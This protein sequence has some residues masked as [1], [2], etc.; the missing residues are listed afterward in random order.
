MEHNVPVKLKAERVWRSYFGGREIDRFHGKD[1]PQDS[2]FP[3]EWVLSAVY[4]NTP[5]RDVVEGV[6]MVMDTTPPM[7]F[8]E[9]IEKDV[10]SVLGKKHKEQFE[11]SPGVLI[12]VLDSAVTLPLQVHP[13]KKA[14]RELFDSQFG[15]IEAWHVLNV[16]DDVEDACLYIGFREGVDKQAFI[17]AF[18]DQD[19]DVMY[20]MMHKIPAVA[21]QT[22]IVKGGM[23]HAIGAG[24][25]LMEIQEPTDITIRFEKRSEMPDAFYHQGLGYETMFDCVHFEGYSYEDLCKEVVVQK[26]TLQDDDDVETVRLVGYDTTPCF[27]MDKMTVKNK[28]QLAHTGEFTGFYVWSGNG[29]LI[30]G[31][32]ELSLEKGEQIFVPCACKEY[33]LANTSQEPLVLFRLLGPKL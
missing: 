18:Y 31:G 7:P 24:C 20:G 33:T 28:V 6:C 9:Y 19:V 26:N 1:N 21:G 32:K 10:D 16:R 5:G 27:A 2:H 4:G 25:T 14:A 22:I 15:K 11:T 12:K 3:E 17:K 23:P 13:D 30:G 8:D 29:T